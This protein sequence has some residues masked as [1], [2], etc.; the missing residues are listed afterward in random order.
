MQDIDID[1]LVDL[2]M[3]NVRVFCDVHGAFYECS[4]A[5]TQIYLYV[6]LI[7]LVLLLVYPVT[8]LLT[9]FWGS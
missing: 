1:D 9:I 4:G 2:K 7:T 5:P 3:D 6:L 8:A